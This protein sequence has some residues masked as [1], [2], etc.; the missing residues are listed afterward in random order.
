MST[1]LLLPRAL[2][3]RSSVPSCFPACITPLSL[4]GGLVGSGHPG[5]D[6]SDWPFS[7]ASMHAAARPVA[8]KP[9]ATVSRTASGRSTLLEQPHLAHVG[10]QPLADDDH[11]VALLAGNRP[12][13]KL[14]DLLFERMDRLEA[15]ISDDLR[16]DPFG[17]QARRC[18]DCVSRRSFQ[19]T[20]WILVAVIIGTGLSGPGVLAS[21]FL[22]RRRAS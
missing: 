11:T 3:A 10:R 21:R 2:H 9:L 4:L 19:K 8:G 17:L 1:Y 12:I 22:I 13:V 6:F 15:S 20:L 16:L 5:P 7:T 18:R 14:G